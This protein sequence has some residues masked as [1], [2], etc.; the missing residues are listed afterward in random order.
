MYLIENDD[1]L[2]QGRSRRFLGEAGDTLAVVLDSEGFVI[3]H[4]L[5]SFIERCVQDSFTSNHGKTYTSFPATEATIAELNDC[6]SGHRPLDM[7][8]IHSLPR[9][10]T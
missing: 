4:G 2:W 9:I 5:E 6:L 7:S 8:V 1:L 3:R 10:A